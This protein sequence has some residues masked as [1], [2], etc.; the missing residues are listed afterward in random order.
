MARYQ[1]GRVDG[2]VAQL[3]LVSKARKMDK[4]ESRALDRGHNYQVEPSKIAVGTGG[5]FGVG[6]DECGVTAM[7]ALPE[8]H[9]DFI[10]PVVANR[11]GLFGCVLLLGLYLWLLCAILAVAVRQR[12]PAGTL[13]CVG[14]FALLGAQGFVNVAMTIGL[15]PIT[16]MTL[17]FVSYGGTSLIVSM[18]A[19]ALV[20]NVAARPSFEFGRGD[21]D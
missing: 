17:P 12:D 13:I 3:P 15:M 5:W 10:F 14:V 1:Q 11:W 2:F 20:C 19:I 16:G 18:V 9:N 21:F 8:R 7:R 4:K 6:E